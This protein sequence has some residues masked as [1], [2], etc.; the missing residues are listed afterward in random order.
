[1]KKFIIILPALVFSSKIFSQHNESCKDV[2]SIPN[3]ERQQFEKRNNLKIESLASSNF[4]VH[5]YRCEWI[6][7][8]AVRYIDGKI[9]SKFITTFATNHIVFD[10]TNRLTVDSIIFRN[11]KTNFTQSAS[12]T[13]TIH[14]PVTIKKNRKDSVTIFYHGVPPISGDFTGG[15]VKSSHNGTPVIWTLSEPYNAQDWWPC[16]NGLDDK[17][18]SI[19]I[20]ITHPSQYKASS[21]GLL[22]SETANGSMTTSW[23]KHRYPIASYLVALAVTNYSVYTRTVTIDDTTL[24]VIS[25]IYPEDL[26]YFQTYTYFVLNA[27]KLYSDTFGNYPYLKERYGQT[28]FGFG[29][30]MEHQTN[31]FVVSAGE[32]LVTHELGHQWFGDKVTCGSWRDIWLNEG[33]ATYMA[34]FF[35]TKNFDTAYYDDYVNGDL[36]Y[37]VSQPD[38]SV[39]VDDT[40]NSGR[41]FDGRLSYDKG[42]FLLRMLQSTLGDS[43]FFEGLRHYLTDP[44]LAYGFAVTADLQRNLEDVSGLNLDYFFNQWFYG[45]GYPSV[46]V[47]WRQAADGRVGLKVSQ[48]TS[49]PSVSFFRMSLPIT[50]KNG[51]LEKKIVIENTQNNQYF[52]LKDPG[53]EVKEI[54]IDPDKY[55][56][57]KDNKVFKAKV[58]FAADEAYY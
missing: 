3:M 27:L 13:L 6:I 16:R 45:Q 41:I 34:D 26:S 49:H 7:D 28:Q 55:F 21:N 31:S 20:Y 57:T 18:D 44:K 9:T 12:K 35:Y 46:T 37:V 14:F 39:W 4:T 32:N 48:T 52:K 15:F 8:P 19:D 25:Y 23:Y 11:K 42:A 10:F 5:Y 17:A 22:Q 1:M 58:P 36:A 40:T 24:P 51:S 47:K 38:G 30:G 53:F 54:L 43:I 29:G 2:F 56:I 33:F 50:L